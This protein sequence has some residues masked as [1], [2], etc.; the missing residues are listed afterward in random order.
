MAVLAP[1]EGMWCAVGTFISGAKSGTQTMHT[2]AL[3]ALL[4]EGRLTLRPHGGVKAGAPFIFPSL[5]TQ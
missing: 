3:T 1:G 2:L 4:C 5:N